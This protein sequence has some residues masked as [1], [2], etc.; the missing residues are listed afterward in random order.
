MAI[1]SSSAVSQLRARLGL[2]ALGV[3]AFVLG[4]SELVV[5]GVLEPVARDVDVSISRAGGLVTA[6]ALGIA[7]GGPLLTALT[8]R[9]ARLFTLKLALAAYVVAT[10]LT[11]VSPTF[12]LLAAS[13]VVTGSLHG[14]F[15]GIA[16]VAAAGIVAPG[17]EGRG[18]AVVFGGIAISTVLGVPVGTLVGQSFGWRDGFAAIVA[19][20]VVAFVLVTAFVPSVRARGNGEMADV[21]SAFAPRVLAALGVGFLLI[22]AQ[23]TALTYLAPFLGSVTGI[24]GSAISVFLLIYGMAI[25]IGVFVGGWAADHGAAL[26]L[27]LANVCHVVVLA[28]LYLVG[29][30]AIPTAI[31]LAVWGVVGF[32]LLSAAVQ[33]RVI[34]LAGPG[35]DLAAT[36]GAS[37]ANA[38]IAVGALTGGQVLAHQGVRSVA[39]AAALISLIAL[40]AT[41]ATRFLRPPTHL[42]ERE[43]A[44]VEPEVQPPRASSCDWSGIVDAD[45][46]GT[47]T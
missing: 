40:P 43:L 35:G 4:T 19:L 46:S 34:S 21:R 25:A 10:V 33:V 28:A 38:G 41:I 30:Q 23:F 44:E 3:S 17:H 42:K 24:T 6:Y 8:G 45:R 15:I 36:L 26:T 11:A 5:V 32:G 39:L 9:W 2:M 18:I 29:P 12:G 47:G 7:V 14:L 13:R 16:S 1:A 20:G 27:L 37:A 31:T 22:G